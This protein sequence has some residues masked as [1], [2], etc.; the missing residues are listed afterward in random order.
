MCVC[1]CVCSGGGTVF[2]AEIRY[3]HDLVRLCCGKAVPH[4]VEEKEMYALPIQGSVQDF[5]LGGGGESIPEKYLEPRSGENIFFR[6]C[7]GSRGMLP[8]KMLK[9]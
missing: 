2:V 4:I 5:L 3:R 6:A 9:T 7:K 8:W 1:V